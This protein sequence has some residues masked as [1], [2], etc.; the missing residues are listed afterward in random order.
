MWSNLIMVLGQLHILRLYCF[1]I[2]NRKPQHRQ[3]NIAAAHSAHKTSSVYTSISHLK[4]YYFTGR[5]E[6]FVTRTVFISE[7][8]KCFKYLLFETNCTKRCVCLNSGYSQFAAFMSRSRNN[9]FLSNN[10]P[11]VV[12]I[13]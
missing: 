2:A 5:N 8:H 3:K 1:H 4:L 12:S 9:I 13:K 7:L 11:P 10:L 6:N